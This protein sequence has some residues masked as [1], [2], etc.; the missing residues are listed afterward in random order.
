LS[1]KTGSYLYTTDTV[2][3]AFT[4]YFFPS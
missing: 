3:L 2:A 1:G 4:Y